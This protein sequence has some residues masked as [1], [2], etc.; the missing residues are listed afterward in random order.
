MKRDVDKT[1]PFSFRIKLYLAEAVFTV[2]D[3]TRIDRRAPQ[4]CTL[5]SYF[6]KLIKLL[7]SRLIKIKYKLG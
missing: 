4:F 3:L 1:F 6:N 7:V 2:F 5:I